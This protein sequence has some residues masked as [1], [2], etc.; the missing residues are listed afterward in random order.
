MHFFKQNF[1]EDLPIYFRWW[2]V[3]KLGKTNE[4]PLGLKYDIFIA[5]GSEPVFKNTRF[6]ISVIKA[7]YHGL[8]LFSNKP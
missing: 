2:N 7:S 1:A 5:K 4:L 6:A 3:T 8:T